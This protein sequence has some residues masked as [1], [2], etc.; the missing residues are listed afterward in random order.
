MPYDITFC[1]GQNCPVKLNCL[2]FTGVSYGRKESFGT[3]P[4]DFIK[5]SCE[6][7]LDDRPDDEKIR[8]LAYQLWQQDGSPHGRDLEYWLQ[9]RTQLIESARNS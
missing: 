5:N 7:Y 9:A 4:Y 6:H 1:T 8:I 2:R 3:V